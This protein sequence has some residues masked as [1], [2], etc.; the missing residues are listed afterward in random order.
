MTSLWLEANASLANP[1]DLAEQ[2]ISDREWAYDRSEAQEL[3]ADV[4]GSWCHYRVWLNWHEAFGAL[5][6]SFATD[7]KIPATM[8]RNVYPLLA[9]ANEK[10][11]LGHFDVTEDGLIVF[12]YS[13]LLKGVSGVSLQQV[14]DLLDIA[15]TECERFYPAFQTV[16]WGGKTAEEALEMA[17]LETV[18]EA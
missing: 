16:I 6:F 3:I 13:M 11:W 17:L 14:E 1:L 9:K 15:M 7:T 18:G 4:A 2:V 8:V 12:R 5:T 10:L